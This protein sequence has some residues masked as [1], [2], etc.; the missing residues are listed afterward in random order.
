MRYLARAADGDP[1]LGDD[2]GVVPLP[3]AAPEHASVRDALPAA[4]AGALPSVDDATADRTPREQHALGAFL[5]DPGKLFG[6]GL[7]YVEHAGDLSEDAPEEPASFF[8]PKT[9]ATGP[10]GPIRLPPESISERVTAEAE[11]AVV[12]GRTCRNVDVDESRGDS[13]ANQNA[14]RSGDVEDADDVIAGFAPVIDMTAEDVLQRNPRFLTRSKSFDT[15]LVLGPYL[16][17]PEAGTDL[18]ETTVRTVVDGETVAE[19]VV[20][21][22]EFPPRELV[23]FHSDVMTLEPGDV[24]STGTPGAGVIEPGSHVRAAVEG[25]GAVAAD[26]VR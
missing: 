17:V 26:V 4:A 9:A 24:I 20:G 2:D 12:I 5:D 10:G 25:I 14:P 16:A 23:A 11:L 8:K 13:S 7:N 15:F 6:I 18:S 19:N 22:M 21:N 1:L 3:A